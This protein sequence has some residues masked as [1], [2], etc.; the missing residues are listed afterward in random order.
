VIYIIFSIMFKF[1]FNL[2][3]FLSKINR[4]HYVSDSYVYLRSIKIQ[5]EQGQQKNIKKE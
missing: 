1:Q 5:N 2:Q 4:R 3:K